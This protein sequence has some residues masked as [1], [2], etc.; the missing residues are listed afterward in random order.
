MKI[1]MQLTKNDSNKIE[2]ILSSEALE[3]YFDRCYDFVYD[4]IVFPASKNITGLTITNHQKQLMDEISKYP[5]VCVE[6]GH[7]TGKSTALSWIGKWFVT[8]R[9]NT[10]GY[11]TK[12]VCLAPTFHQLYDILWPEFRRWLPLSRLD[13]LFDKR[14]DEIFI[15]GHKDSSFIRARSPKEPENVQGFHSAHLLWLIDEAF[16]IHKEL[17]WETIEGSFTED[18][19]KIIIAGQHTSITGYCHDAFNKDKDSWRQLRFDSEKS[20]IAKPEYGQRIARKYGITSDI[21]RVRVKGMAPKGNPDAFIQLEQ[22]ERAKNREVP[23]TNHL[24]MGVDCARFGDDMTVSTTRSGNHVFPQAKLPRSDTDDI[25][26]LVLDELRKYRKL[27]GYIGRVDIKVDSTGGYGA[28][29]VDALNK[30]TTDN[31]RVIPINFGGGGDEEYKDDVSVMWGELR[32]KIEY[33]QLPDSD[34]LTE[35]LATRR[36]GI[37]TDGRTQLESKKLFKKDYG[38]SPDSSDSLVLCFTSKAEKVR[39]LAN[40][41]ATDPKHSRLYKVD[42]GKV[43]P[44]EIDVYG[45]LY[46]DK[47]QS[48]TGNFFFWNRYKRLL[49]VY[50]QLIHRNPTPEALVHDLRAQAQIPLNKV[51]DYGV[52]VKDIFGN[53]EM[54][55]YGK[56]DIVHKMLKTGVRL[57]QNPSYNEA[58]AILH[59]NRLFDED[60]ILV[61]SGLEETDWQYRNWIIE[62]GRPVKG[63]PLCRALCIIVNVLR[64]KGAFKVEPDLKP[65]G[66]QMRRIREH[67]GNLNFDRVPSQG[68]VKRRDFDDYLAK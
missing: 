33:V 39:V 4:N 51:N 44:E 60:K 53:D 45:V 64:E 35:E 20:P 54:F 10:L 23:L 21:Y 27:T 14:T 50:S 47:D 46:L 37:S 38:A 31:I 5:R 66:K 40:Y 12:V 43:N 18:D 63:Y 55:V 57:K 67:L 28:G 17:V 19:N 26:K 8:T 36:F 11:L 48:I 7:G 15:K 29:A 58:A 62:N 32:D 30:N 22:V 6:S 52:A 61:N 1:R 24:E 41:I 42:W 59:A 56:D 9:H 16:G 68:V 3:Y 13:P 25:V 49:R 2:P 34:I 65:Y